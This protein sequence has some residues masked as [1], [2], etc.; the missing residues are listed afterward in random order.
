MSGFL[1]PAF[2]ALLLTIA[3]HPLRGWVARRGLPGW[4]GSV[5]GLVS[6][7][8][9]LLGLAVSLVVSAAQFATLLPTYEPQMNRLLDEVTAWL[10]R[11]GVGQQQIQNLLSGADVGKLV[12]L[13][14]SLAS[15]LLGVLSSLFFVVTLVL[16]MVAD[17]TH[18]PDSLGRLPAE[19]LPLVRALGTFAVGTRRYLVVSTVFGLAV[20]VVD[21]VALVVIGVPVAL[22]WGLLSF[23]TNYIPNIGFVIGLVP[24]AVIGLLE[25]GPKMMLAVVIAYCVANVLIQTVI[26]PKIVGDVVGLSTTLTMLSV[27]FWALVLGPLG[28][29]MAVPLTVLVKGLLVDADPRAAWLQ[30]LLAAPPHPRASGWRRRSR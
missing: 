23:I 7:Y 16:F 14:G 22:L 9:F 4:L 19:R 25:G 28:A 12:S 27:V 8:A 13:A 15:G 30:P 11:A 26:Q 5:T 17:A 20:A 1:G 24:P 2:L 29:L 18:V 3:V 21:V 6:V 10:A